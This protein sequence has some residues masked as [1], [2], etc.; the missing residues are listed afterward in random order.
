MGTMNTLRRIVWGKT[1]KPGP[2]LPD[3][4]DDA[5]NTP[6]WGS[7]QR[8]FLRAAEAL[9][10]SDLEAGKYVKTRVTLQWNGSHLKVWCAGIF[11]D[12]MSGSELAERVGKRVA[13]NGEE[14]GAWTVADADCRLY[15]FAHGQW[16]FRIFA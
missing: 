6:T 15:H 11:M 8:R 9:G 7:V 13:R 14:R 12:I 5:W 16:G 2:L 10:V 1:P 3:E 4:G